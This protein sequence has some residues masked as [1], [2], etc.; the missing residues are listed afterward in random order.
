M[1]KI[2]CFMCHKNGQYASQFREKKEKGK[3]QQVVAS[4]E[5]ELSEFTVNFRSGCS[6]V[7]CLSTNT[8][9]RSAWYLDSGASHHMTKAWE[10]FSRLTKSNSEIHVELGDDAKYAVRG[11]GVI[12]FKLELGG[13]LGFL[14]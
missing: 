9:V 14:S 6:L 3:S 7:L 11:E 2:K 10:L 8:V 12:S 13:S 5:N 4:I 1:S